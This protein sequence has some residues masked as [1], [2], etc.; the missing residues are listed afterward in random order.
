MS[1]VSRGEGLLRLLEEVPRAGP[2][3]RV[4]DLIERLRRS[5]TPHATAVYVTDA[6][7]RLLGEVPF[8]ELLRAEPTALAVDR[9][10]RGV[11]SAAADEDQERVAQTALRHGAAE[12]AVLDPRGR[13]LGVV[14]VRA[15][16]GVLYEE[17]IEDLHRLAGVRREQTQ[18][19]AA[20]EEPPARQ[21]GDRLPWLVV[22][23]AGCAVATWV[24]ARFE[25]ALEARV[26]LAFFVPG[27]V[28]LA[29]AI[30]T[31]TEAIVVRGLSLARMPLRTLL[32][33]ELRAGVL[34]GLALGALVFPAVWLAFGDARLA[35][36]VAG[37]LLGA[38]GAASALGLLLPWTLAR[39]GA[40]PAF[41]AGPVATIVQ[42]VLS[43]LIYLGLA[44]ALLP[45][46]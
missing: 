15:L 31:Q 11:P 19:R 46:S 17:H 3:E 5:G 20:L 2:Q 44:Q 9:M 10:S 35:L 13:L 18:A 34:I 27:I 7:G 42:D 22:G 38:G 16:L 36:V 33:H 4:S 23:L 43:L 28:Y 41:G 32:D 25:A 30:G 39:L 21:V 1:G 12:V 8:G 6:D 40:D 37:A 29:D 45:R 24:M 14:P 26:A